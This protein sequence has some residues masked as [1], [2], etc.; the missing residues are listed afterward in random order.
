MDAELNSFR[1]YLTVLVRG[2]IPVDLRARLDASDIVQET[3]LE[4]FRKKDQYR[5]T[6]DPKQIAGWLRQ[7]LSCNWIDAIR[8]QRRDSRDV[9]REQSLAQAIDESSLG[10]EQLLAME[11]STPSQIIEK[12][13]RALRVARAFDD[14]P[15][16]QRDAVMLRYFQ[17]ASLEQIAEQMNKTKPAVAGLLKRGL[18][19]LRQS[20]R[21]EEL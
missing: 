15:K 11:Q 17:R 10:L 7:I 6:D 5:G 18:E 14:L 13:F 16:H 20:L 19:S 1:P 8:A 2:Q 3:L 4:A 12:R 21:S 9:G